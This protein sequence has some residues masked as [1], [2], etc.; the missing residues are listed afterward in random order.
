MMY[1]VVND[2]TIYSW[3]SQ[4]IYHVKLH[5]IASYIHI[6]Y[7]CHWCSETQQVGHATAKRVIEPMHA[8]MDILQL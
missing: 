7:N 3:Q 1:T 4:I 6:N 2:S 5:Y 8:S